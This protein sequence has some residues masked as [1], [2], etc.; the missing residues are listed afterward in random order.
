MSK[1]RIVF[2]QVLTLVVIGT[3]VWV[4]WTHSPAISKPSQLTPASGQAS[5]GAASS[6]ALPSGPVES[7][8][9]PVAPAGPPLPATTEPNSL[10]SA[11]AA[12]SDTTAA[13]P[14]KSARMNSIEDRVLELQGKVMLGMGHWLGAAGSKYG[15]PEYKD[16]ARG[17]LENFV[18]TDP[19]KELIAGEKQEPTVLTKTA[20]MRL[21]I[22]LLARYDGLID[23]VT[24]EETKLIEQVQREHLA[25]S[26]TLETA[27]AIVRGQPVA[28]TESQRESL[29]ASMG[30]YGTLA[31]ALA[32]SNPTKREA[33]VA[34][35]D[36]NAARAAMGLMIVIGVGIFSF[37][38]F[39]VLFFKLVRGKLRFVFPLPS[40][41]SPNFGLEIFCLY[42]LWMLGMA[43]FLG[44]IYEAGFTFN[45]LVANVVGILASLVVLLWPLVWGQRLREVQN[46]LGFRLL[47][48]R[49]FISDFFAAPFTY[50]CA[51]SVLLPVMAVYMLVLQSLGVSPEQGEHPV[52]PLLLDGKKGNDATLW[53]AF[54]AVGVAPFI[55]EIMFRGALY[56][57]MR[58]RLGAFLSIVLSSIIFAVVHPQGAVGVLPLTIIGMVLAFLREWRGTLMAPMLAHACFNAGTLIMVIALFR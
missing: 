6:K 21:K 48:V 29:T 37:L 54:L 18:R 17:P 28:L 52:V 10:A 34:G 50:L 20:L 23:M 12:T 19:M 5:S 30:W 55:E 8:P 56:G 46:F 31:I 13:A 41:L 42:L 32:E 45:P 49:K 44:Y 27:I 53:I 15:V 35:I 2:F 51:W 58:T 25:S 47:G 16:V 24:P 14:A 57:W 11:P 40:G 3:V 22:L 36:Q 43:K 7:L 9:L 33:L 38:G 4:S 39:L 26:P 1:S